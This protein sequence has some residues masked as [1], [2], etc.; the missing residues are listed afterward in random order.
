MKSKIKALAS[1]AASA[2]IA[3]SGIGF[4][5]VGVSAAE[6]IPELAAGDIGT[7]ER[8]GAYSMAADDLLYNYMLTQSGVT[9]KPDNMRNGKPVY[10][11]S[12]IT[13]GSRLTGNEAL[14][15][16]YLKTKIEEIAAGERTSTEIEIPLEVFGIKAGPWSASEL[17]VSSIMSGGSISNDAANALWAKVS[18]DMGDIID[19]LLV[20]CPY[21]LYWYDKTKGCSSREVGIHTEWEDGEYKLYLNGCPSTTFYVSVDYS[22][23]HAQNA[24][25]LPAESLGTVKTAI[26]NAQA[27]VDSNS[28][29]RGKELLYAFARAIC[30]ANEY[31][32][33]AA[34]GGVPYG[35]PWQL[36]YVFDGDDSTNVV[37]EGYAKAFKYLCDLSADKLPDI[38]C[39]LVGGTTGGGH[40]WN[41][42]NMDDDRSY[43][44]DVTF[45][46]GIERPLQEYTDT[47]FLSC[48]ESGDINTGYT[49]YF[50]GGFY[51]GEHTGYGEQWYTYNYDSDT[52]ASYQSKYL[53]LSTEPYTGPKA[54]SATVYLVDFHGR[55]TTETIADISAYTLP[56]VYYDGYE[57]KGWNVNGTLCETE[58]AAKDRII[59]L[60]EGDN[61]ITVRS[62]YARKQASYNVNVTGGKLSNKRTSCTAQVSSVITVRADKAA[63]G[64]KFSH[65]LRNGVKVSNNS[66]YSFRMPS[67]E[68]ELQAVFVSKSTT[69]EKS[70]TAI[71]ESVTPN[72][73]TG[74]I[75]FVSVLNVPAD[76][77][78]V[79]GGLVATSK[80]SIG[81]NVTAANAD[82]VKLSTVANADTKN[83]KYTWTKTRVTTDTI[84]YVKGY[85]VYE[86]ESGTEHTVY[87]DCVKAKING[88]VE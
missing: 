52:L 15:Y 49:F 59:E 60:A 10:Y 77:T 16:N 55:K 54:V 30:D 18:Y 4:R 22:E 14:V 25:S 9:P 3:M 62:V 34:G 32:N 78:F 53:T 1:L 46:D 11:E 48:P 43:H 29:K 69:V 45:L 66:S 17:G 31:N 50:P 5:A 6:E 40:M 2:A 47:F 57:L 51:P 23:N 41:V 63:S 70:G 71:I 82:Y 68:V 35:D 44:V 72:Q 26:A 27:I 36:V 88:V 85:L 86:D 56:S 21:S 80:S 75:S 74:K 76:C 81:E 67:Y 58:E 33:S 24:T 13:A 37:C 73:S 64:K 7:E 61:T 83:L 79:K 12:G 20:D 19:A 87:S 65:W 84:W 28:D 8:L 42:V 39:I 38:S